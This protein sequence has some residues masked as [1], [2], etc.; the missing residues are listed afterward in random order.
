[1]AGRNLFERRRIVNVLDTI[2]AENKSPV[3][4]RLSRVCLNDFL[5]ELFRLVKLALDTQ[6][7]G[8]VEQILQI[9]IHSLRY[10]LF[11]T[12]IFTFCDDYTFGDLKVSTAHFTFE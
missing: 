3:R 4:F 1:M 8:A 2:L 11:R 5:I 12:A 6:G 9:F 10:G 7:I